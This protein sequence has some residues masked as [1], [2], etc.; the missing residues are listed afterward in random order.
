MMNPQTQQEQPHLVMLVGNLVVGDSRVL[1]S[2]ESAQKAGYRVTIVGERNRTV[3]SFGVHHDIPIYRVAIPFDRHTRYLRQAEHGS[4]RDAWQDPLRT[5]TAHNASE[6]SSST[7]HPPQ[8]FRSVLSRLTSNRIWAETAERRLSRQRKYAR[9]WPLIEDYEEAFVRALVALEPDLIHVHDRHPMPAA[10]TY[11]AWRRS[12]NRPVQ[13]VYD[14]H[15]WLPGVHFVGPPPSGPAWIAAERDLIHQADAV[16]SVSDV[17]ADRMQQR[18]NL[19]QRPDV[20]VNAPSAGRHPMDPAIR[21]TLREECGLDAKTPLV[22]Y[23]GKLSKARGIFDAV[24]ALAHVPN[25]HLAFVCNR[26]QRTRDELMAAAQ[27]SHLADRIHL[28]DYVPAHN[29]T[30]Y[31]ESATAGLSPLHATTAHEAA[32]ATKIREY[33]QAGLPLVVSDVAAQSEFVLR[34]GLGTVHRAADIRDLARAISDVLD[35]P[36]RFADALTPELMQAHTWE[37]SEDILQRVWGRLYPLPSVAQEPVA[38]SIQP[39]SGRQD[40]SPQDA[41]RQDSLS[42]RHVDSS[43]YLAVGPD[44]PVIQT[45]LDAAAELESRGAASA[46]TIEPATPRSFA[47]TS[48]PAAPTAPNLFGQLPGLADA[49]RIVAEIAQGVSC[50]FLGDASSPLNG[51]GGLP[52]A[53]QQTIS[54]LGARIVTLLDPEAMFD[55][56]ILADVAPLH[57]LLGLAYPAGTRYDRQTT[58]IRRQLQ[59]GE[60]PVLTWGELASRLFPHAVWLPF[61]ARAS[62]RPADEEAPRRLLIAGVRRSA[63]ETQAIEAAMTLWRAADYDVVSLPAFDPTSPVPAELAGAGPGSVMVDS[64][65]AGEPSPYAVMAWAHGLNVVGG[66][67]HPLREDLARQAPLLQ[68]DLQTLSQIVLGLMEQNKASAAAQTLRTRAQSYVDRVHRQEFLTRLQR[69]VTG[70]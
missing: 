69:A 26:D 8:W 55:R 35:A 36:D 66:T 56:R 70:K 33:V 37:G 6:A 34:H 63:S 58:R 57:P 68:A 18:H 10:A 65:T 17:L 43:R 11:A 39:E 12:T 52:A 50:V 41:P 20:V 7:T 13:W 15:E 53:E 67:P 29:V 21:R 1:K 23:V 54:S 45:V 19:A 47:A 3:T 16:I 64:L 27:A 30:W 42:T 22:V 5:A 40:L 61:P 59:H 49:A 60:W 9:Q 14:A 48:R 25:A 2:A 31:V 38:S 32:L 51:H 46:A 62:W 4:L 24:A 44:S 28:V